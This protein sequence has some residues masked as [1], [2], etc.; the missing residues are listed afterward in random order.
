MARTRIVEEERGT[1]LECRAVRC[2]DLAMSGHLDA[3]GGRR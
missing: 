1:W 2:P 3:S